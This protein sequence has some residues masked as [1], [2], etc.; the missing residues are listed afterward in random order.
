M[1]SSGPEVRRSFSLVGQHL[2]QPDGVQR[3]QQRVQHQHR[4]QLRAGGV[5]DEHEVAGDRHDAQCG[6]R[7]H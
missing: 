1:L 2:P 5:G 4:H 3:Q 7:A 6:D